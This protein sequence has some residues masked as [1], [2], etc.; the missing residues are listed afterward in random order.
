MTVEISEVSQRDTLYPQLQN[1]FYFV[2]KDEELSEANRKRYRTLMA[3][4]DNRR[5]P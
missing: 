5:A 2:W 3:S 1:N 4:Q